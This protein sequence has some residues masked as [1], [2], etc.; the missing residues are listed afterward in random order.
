LTSSATVRFSGRILLRGVTFSD[1]ELK[2]RIR[3]LINTVITLTVR[4][5]FSHGQVKVLVKI[6]STV[7]SKYSHC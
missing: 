1:F 3:K 4:S 7:R 2:W 6:R 5:K